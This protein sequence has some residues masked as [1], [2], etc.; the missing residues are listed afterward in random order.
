MEKVP[1]GIEFLPNLAAGLTQTCHEFEVVDCHLS[2]SYQGQRGK[3]GVLFKLW[4]PTIGDYTLRNLNYF[5]SI[6]SIFVCVCVCVCFPFENVN[7]VLS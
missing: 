5:C 3:D 4:Q 6:V 7:G 2:R 1:G